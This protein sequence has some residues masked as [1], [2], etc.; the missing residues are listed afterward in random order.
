MKTE[1]EKMVNGELFIAVDPELVKDREN[2][3][4]LA[5]LY[6]Q[7]TETDE[8]KRNKVYSKTPHKPVFYDK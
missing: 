7:T 2:A 4:R 8:C 5:R 1:K 3:R 6:N